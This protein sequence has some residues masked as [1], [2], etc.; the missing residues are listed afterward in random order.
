MCSECCLDTK[1]GVRLECWRCGRKYHWVCFR[2]EGAPSRYPDALSARRGD[3]R[4]IDFVCEPCNVRSHL[5]RW[6][7]QERDFYL[8][9]LDRMLTIDEFHKDS[10]G[11]S[12]KGFTAL[13]QMARWG[14]WAGIP[15][16]L[17]GCASEL[18]TMPVDHRQ[19][20]WFL[21]HKATTVRYD[22]VRAFRSAVWNYYQRMP[23][24][25][26]GRGPTDT[27]AFGHRLD[28]MMQRL[29]VRYAQ[30]RVF[31][32][33][34]LRAVVTRLESDW[35]RAPP[36][37]RLEMCM[38]NTAFH[39]YF[40]A[41]FRANE[42][43]AAT[44]GEVLAALVVEHE[45]VVRGV[46]PHVRWPCALQTKE[47]RVS[48]TAVPVSLTT[49]PPCPLQVGTWLSRLFQAWADRGTPVDTTDTRL[50][51]VHA[52]GRPW[53]M[54]WYWK[55]HVQRRL[56]LLREHELGGLSADSDIGGYGSNS[57][58]RTWN[59]MAAAQPNPVSKDLRERQGRWRT[60]QRR[61]Q[62]PNLEMPSLYCD[63]DLVERLSAT[64]FLSAIGEGAGDD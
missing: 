5:G 46:P 21:E 24:V 16:M 42:A 47:N 22:T 50:L 9:Y 8:C 10:A 13:R 63:P 25:H 27:V 62:R 37:R 35:E 55:T 38:V 43:F 19:L 53:T 1:A 15:T 41:G 6:P 56:F 60:H 39:L 49:C 26:P 17:A 64:Y 51:F 36:G 3:C 32:T 57:P 18:H 48:Q 29:G 7:S 31:S 52:N 23:G 4:R 12:E 2:V 20:G 14:A 61:R 30:H 11:S 33:V 40:T 54:Q 59:T 28:G 58:R 45:A 34:L 44:R